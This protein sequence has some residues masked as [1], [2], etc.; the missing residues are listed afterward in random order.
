MRRAALVLSCVLA[1][2]AV[3]VGGPLDGVIAIPAES[4]AAPLSHT[5]AAAIEGAT[6]TVA[7]AHTAEVRA[8]ADAEGW[9][10]RALRALAAGVL[11]LLLLLWDARARS[12]AAPLA[13]APRSVHLRTNLPSRGPPLLAA[14]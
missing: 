1:A 8:A 10:A 14:V 11:P 12:R 5:G 2:L 13:L 4:T 9:R 3:G 6:D 7:T